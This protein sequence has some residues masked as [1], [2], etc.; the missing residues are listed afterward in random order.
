LWIVPAQVDGTW[1]SERGE[2]KL[3][4]RYQYFKGTLGAAEVSNGRVR[5]DTLNFMVDGVSYS[6]RVNA[7]GDVIEGN[8]GDGTVRWRAQRKVP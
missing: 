1:Q 6:G 5:G 3:T 7:A 2:L 4:Q 8:I